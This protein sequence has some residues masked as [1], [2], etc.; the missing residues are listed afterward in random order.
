MK[1]QML[2]YFLTVTKEKSISKA[3]NKLF[4]S[5]PALSKQI[6]KLEEILG[7]SLFIR[8]SNGMSLTSKGENLYNDLEPLIHKLQYQLEKHMKDKVIRM[9]SDPLLASYYFPEYIE[10]INPF[11]IQLTKIKDDTLD[12]I[13]LLE[14]GEIDAAIIQDHPNQKGLHSTF[15]F[16]DEFYAAVPINHHFARLES[17]SVTDCFKF[18]QMLPPSFTPLYQKIK[19]LMD[20]NTIHLPEIIEIPYHALIGFVAQGYGISYLPS[21]MVEKID[22]KGVAF[23]PLQDTPIKREMYLYALDKDTLKTLK[24]G[25]DK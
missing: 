25:F 15:L 6:R 24:L 14:S 18:T 7:F 9:G 17:I 1:L 11:K 16:S 19:M 5:Q 2:E 4:V 21:I 13:P 12:L 10:Q 20:K 3:A 8:S 23:I 22:Y